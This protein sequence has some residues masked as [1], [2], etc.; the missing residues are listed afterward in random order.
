MERGKGKGERGI[1]KLNVIWQKGE[2]ERVEVGSDEMKTEKECE[3]LR[4]R[5]RF[6]KEYNRKRLLNPSIDSEEEE[7]KN[8]W[9]LVSSLCVQCRKTCIPVLSC[10]KFKS[11]RFN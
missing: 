10:S 1:L 8:F 6:C 7:E 4:R 11:S 2:R 9:G 5:R 3:Q